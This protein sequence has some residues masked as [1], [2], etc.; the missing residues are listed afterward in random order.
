[1]L[2]NIQN[3]SQDAERFIEVMWDLTKPSLFKVEIGIDAIDRINLLRDITEVIS[4]YNLNITN[5]AVKRK[6]S[7][8]EVTIRFILEIGDVILL[9]KLLDDIKNIDS[10]YDSYRTTPGIDR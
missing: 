3:L 9:N 6:E 10:I 5:I 4:D 8:N 7:E 2:P 1:M